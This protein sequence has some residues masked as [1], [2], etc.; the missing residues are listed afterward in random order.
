MSDFRWSYA[1][2]QWK[3]TEIDFIRREQIES[4]FKTMSSVGFRAA[5]ITDMA[6]GGR[7]MMS[8]FYGSPQGFLEFARNCGVDCVSSF[9]SGIG[10]A[11]AFG[12]GAAT[13][14]GDHDRILESAKELAGFIAEV[15]GS[16]LVAKPMGPYWK[17]APVTKDKVAIAADCWNAAGKA[18]RAL[19]VKTALHLDFFGSLHDLNEIETFLALTDPKSVGLTLDTAELTIAGIDPVAFYEKYHDRIWHMHFKDAVVRDTTGEYKKPGAELDYWPAAMVLAGLEQGIER[20]YYEMGTPGGLVDFPALVK[21]MKR[22]G[23]DGWIVAESDQSPHTEES[24][25]L[26]GWYRKFVLKS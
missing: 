25:L 26:N 6:I 4:A 18:T 14:R 5:E 10:S 16:A 1:V 11:D 17:E 3:N 13:D 12:G 22:F 24:V 15:G 20:W 7:G 2:N 21:A 8:A 23:Y 19:G 9:L